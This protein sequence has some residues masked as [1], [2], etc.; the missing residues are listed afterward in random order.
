MGRTVTILDV[1]DNYLTSSRATDFSSLTGRQLWRLGEEVRV[2]AENYQH[3]SA[4]VARMPVYLE[5]WPSANFFL[6]DQ[7]QLV[8]STLLYSG[9][10]TPKTRYP[11]GSQ[12][13]AIATN[14]SR[15]ADRVI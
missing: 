9:R 15:A 8:L 4:D 7:G 11:T 14:T 13:S 6:S 10:S 3:L 5:G 1:L 2:F 12:P